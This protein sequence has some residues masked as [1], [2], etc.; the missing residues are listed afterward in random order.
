MLIRNDNGDPAIVKV[1]GVTDF[2]LTDKGAM[3]A[4]E[5][6]EGYRHHSSFAM[7]LPVI[8]GKYRNKPWDIGTYK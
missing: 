5:T 4:G 6:S 7:G 1:H 2:V 8:T 3:Y